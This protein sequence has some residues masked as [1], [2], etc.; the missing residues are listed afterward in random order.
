MAGPHYWLVMPAAGRGLRMAGAAR[1]P[2]Q[3]LPL[4]GRTVI[5]HALA[6][7]LADPRCR[8]AVVVHAPDDATFRTLPPA[9]DPRVVAV[10]GGA[11]RRDSVAAGLAALTVQVGGD[12]PWVLVHDAV[13]PCLPSADLEALLAALAGSPAGALLG[14]RVADTLKRADAGGRVEVTVARERL[15]RAQTP[16]AFRLRRLA[17]AIAVAAAATDEASAVEA[18]GDQPL[19]VPGSADNHK[20]TEPADVALA[21]RILAGRAAPDRVRIGFGIDVHG[22]GPGDHVWLGGQRVPH[23]QGVVAHSDGDVLLHALCDA[24][25][26]A[27]GLGDIGDHFPDTEARWRG[28]ASTALLRQVLELVRGAGWRVGNADL[29]LLAEAPRLA[30]WRG[31][32][33]ERLAAE[34]GV[35]VGRVS[36]KAT[37][38]ERLGFIGRGEGLAAEAAVLL[39]RDS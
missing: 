24:L 39:E 27:A 5:E 2:K 7:F 14:L 25:L 26:G 4:A 11:E 37:T 16:Q 17:G 35:P 36:V 20:F 10:H 15:W 9:A 23:S 1:C 34:L 13:R 6:P 18:L 29:T 12:D 38:T 32:I 31:P 21:A 8:G 19:L 30:P 33:R 22:F 28:A 3:Y